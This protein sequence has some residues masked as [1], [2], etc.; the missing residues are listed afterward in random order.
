MDYYGEQYLGTFRVPNT[1]T[2]KIVGNSPV[3]GQNS[4]TIG[5][6]SLSVGATGGAWYIDQNQQDDYFSLGKITTTGYDN[7]VETVG[8]TIVG[9][10]KVTVTMEEKKLPSVF[11]HS[12]TVF[13][14][15]LV[16]QHGSQVLVT[17]IFKDINLRMVN[18]K[19]GI[20]LQVQYLEHSHALLRQP[21]T[22]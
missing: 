7:V 6:L 20:Q 13:I 8:C 19:D 21:I 9:S 14:V 5:N 17:D 16:I 18:F 3:F 2:K 4:P 10:Q 11:Q 1:V 12:H 15:F 22:R